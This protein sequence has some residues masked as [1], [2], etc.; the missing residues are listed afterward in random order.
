[1]STFEFGFGNN[2][3]HLLSRGLHHWQDAQNQAREHENVKKRTSNVKERIKKAFEWHKKKQTAVSKHSFNTD[4]DS[5]PQQ[6]LSTETED[7]IKAYLKEVTEKI[8]VG[9]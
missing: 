1:M 2:L 6:R 7:S 8:Y 9:R 3:G 4:Q 5:Y